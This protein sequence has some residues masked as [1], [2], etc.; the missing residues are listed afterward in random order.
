MRA[1]VRACV[2]ACMRVCVR[3][4]VCARARAH[5][6]ACVCVLQ[7]ETERKRMKDRDVQ[8]DRERLKALKINETKLCTLIKMF[9]SSCVQVAELD[10]LNHTNAKH[11]N[12]KLYSRVKFSV[13]I[14][15]R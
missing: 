2:H 15:V 11:R 8:S 7:R 12:T 3:V 1:C 5:A 9:S 10:K 4:C 13:H 6:R 14:K